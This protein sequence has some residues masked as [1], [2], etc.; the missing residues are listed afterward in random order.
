MTEPSLEGFNADK[1]LSLL[2]NVD[3]RKFGEGAIPEVL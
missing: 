1:A 3:L 2:L